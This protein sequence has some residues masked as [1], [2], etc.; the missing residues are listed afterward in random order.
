MLLGIPPDARHLI[1]AV[2]EPACRYA[3]DGTRVPVTWP[4]DC[5]LWGD[6]PGEPLPRVLDL[7]G[8]ARVLA[9]G[10]YY[11]LPAGRWTMRAILAFSPSSRGASLALELHGAT[12]LARFQFT[13]DQPGLFAASLPVTIPSPREP[14]EMRLVTERGAIEGTL[15]ID[16]AEF[17]PE[18]A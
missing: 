12:E 17:I 15:G 1:T 3:L 4:R 11:A 10:P 5:L 9:Y 18:P 13:V 7:T 8:P 14:L 6:R 16:R 2:V